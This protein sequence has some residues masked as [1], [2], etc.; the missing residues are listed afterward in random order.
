MIDLQHLGLVRSMSITDSGLAHLKGLY[1]VAVLCL[2]CTGIGD[3]GMKHL[4]CLPLVRLDLRQATITTVGVKFIAASFPNLTDLNLRYASG[5]EADAAAYL[6]TLRNLTHVNV[7]S[8]GVN[9]ED[10][11]GI[12]FYNDD[13]PFHDSEYGD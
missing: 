12:S 11:A 7:F 4:Q 10:L 13:V 6:A 5:V 1:K 3:S 2:G 9:T 8:T